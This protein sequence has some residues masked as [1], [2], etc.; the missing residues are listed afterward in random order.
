[1]KSFQNNLI[2]TYTSGHQQSDTDTERGQGRLAGDFE[3]KVG[4]ESNGKGSNTA[5]DLTVWN[6]LAQKV[7]ETK[8]DGCRKCLRYPLLSRRSV[9]QC[10]GDAQNRQKQNVKP[11]RHQGLPT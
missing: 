4:V 6:H 2:A 9:R 5:Y 10:N 7:G 11:R 1:M 3:R 8:G